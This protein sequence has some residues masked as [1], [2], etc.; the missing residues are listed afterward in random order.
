MPPTCKASASIPSRCCP[1]PWA[2]LSVLLEGLSALLHLESCPATPKF[3][4][5]SGGAQPLVQ[6]L[7]PGEP[8]GP[9]AVGIETEVCGQVDP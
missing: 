6:L 3:S 5:T 1:E 8:L 9:G 2:S 7:R 4:G